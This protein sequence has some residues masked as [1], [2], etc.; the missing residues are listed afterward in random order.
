MAAVYNPG[1]DLRSDRLPGISLLLIKDDSV[2][3]VFLQDE[4]SRS[5]DDTVHCGQFAVNE[6]SD[7]FE[8]LAFQNDKQVITA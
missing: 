5:G 3:L 1:K 2:I 6:G 8:R 4:M 7:V